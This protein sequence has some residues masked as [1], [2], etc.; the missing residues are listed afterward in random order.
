MRT[1]GFLGGPRLVPPRRLFGGLSGST[2]LALAIVLLAAAASP[3]MAAVT[4]T[5]HINAGDSYQTQGL[6]PDKSVTFVAPSD[7]LQT[8]TFQQLFNNG[9][10]PPTTVYARS[11]EAMMDGSD[12]SLGGYVHAELNGIPPRFDPQLGIY[13][14]A[15]MWGSDFFIAQSAYSSPQVE[16]AF[17]LAVFGNGRVGS[18]YKV[19][20]VQNN[21]GKKQL[22]SLGYNDP[23]N[24][25]V[26]GTTQGSFAATVGGLYYIEYSLLV[27]TGVSIYG[28]STSN[29]TKSGVSDYLHTAHVYID[30]ITSGA[31]IL[32][33]SGHNYAAPLPVPEPSSLVLMLAGLPWLMRARRRA[34][35]R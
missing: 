20:E 24:G 28:L 25:Q 5:L 32:A 22:L 31:S 21:G 27:S 13:A 29:P 1:I 10:T 3:A 14:Q 23:G 8:L 16:L 15:S 26:T 6:V 7:P 2:P 35:S 9:Q 11:A 4:G 12:G 19:F 30:P 33:T 17:Q 34:P 18:S